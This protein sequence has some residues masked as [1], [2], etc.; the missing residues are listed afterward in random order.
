MNSFMW[1]KTKEETGSKNNQLPFS[2]LQIPC[3]MKDPGD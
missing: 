3:I 2:K 1:L